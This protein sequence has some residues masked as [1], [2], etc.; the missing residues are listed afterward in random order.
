MIELVLI[1]TVSIGIGYLFATIRPEQ[2][3]DKETPI[4]ELNQLAYDMNRKRV[5][6]DIQ[7]YKLQGYISC[8]VTIYFSQIKD[9]LRT[10]GYHLRHV[11]NDTYEVD[12]RING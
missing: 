5:L 8:W 10:K 1:I 7:W 3:T 9:E 12:W 6:E 2:P 11:C 4:T